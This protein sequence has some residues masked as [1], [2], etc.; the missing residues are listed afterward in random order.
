M[1]RKYSA[2]ISFV[3]QTTVQYRAEIL[4]WLILDML[5][6]FILFFV[7]Q[8]LY[9][10]MDSLRNVTFQEVIQYYVLV[11]A[12]DRLTAIHFEGWRSDE[13]RHGKIDY[14]LTRPFSYLKSIF[15]HDVGG[16]IYSLTLFIPLFTLFVIAIKAIFGLA[17]LELSFTE[18]V[19]AL[20]F[21]A[22][23]FCIQFLM[24]VWIVLMTFWF[25]MARGFEHFKTAVITLFSGYLLPM[26]FLPEWL[27]KIT[28]FLPF[29][30]LY[31]V[32]ISALQGKTITPNDALYGIATV[33]VMLC[34]THVLWQRAL[35]QYSSVGG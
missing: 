7:W 17:P 5:P 20:F 6:F 9:G 25:E 18:L 14:F 3:I 2:I 32:P 10:G 28:S 15:T 12:I 4:I 31:W 24:G 16:R 35:Y 30:F 26:A 22:I 33:S 29:K 13:I 1:W 23:S 19:V 21:V 27:E 34:I 11:L 8:A